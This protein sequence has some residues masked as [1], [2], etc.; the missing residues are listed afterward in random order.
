MDIQLQN[1][2]KRLVEVTALVGLS[3]HA[4][5]EAKVV[6]ELEK[7]AFPAELA[8]EINEE[9]DLSISGFYKRAGKEMNKHS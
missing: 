5:R 7:Y 8:K 1:Q 9:G 2:L 4:H 6:K 3:L